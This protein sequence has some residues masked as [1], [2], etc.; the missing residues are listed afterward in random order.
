MG[1]DLCGRDIE[2]VSVLIEGT[3]LKVCSSCSKFGLTVES[4][5]KIVKPSIIVRNQVESVVVK[6]F[7]RLI[8]QAR[9]KLNLEH[10]IKKKTGY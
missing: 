1:C 7:P 8:K 6:D 5:T 9:E 4:K 10:W 2:L 3:N